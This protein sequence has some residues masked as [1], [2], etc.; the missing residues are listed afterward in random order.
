MNNG[1]RIQISGGDGSL[2][3]RFDQSVGESFF[4][5]F[6]QGRSFGDACLRYFQ[7]DLAFST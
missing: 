5:L 6:D 4:G 3:R 7:V 1:S 2:E